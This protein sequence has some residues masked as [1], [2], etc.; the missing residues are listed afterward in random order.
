MKI[1]LNKEEA[2]VLV[3]LLDVAVKSGGLQ[4]AEAALYFAKKVDTAAK[5]E[6]KAEE[7]PPS[8]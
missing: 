1:D 6:A 2:Q 7:M 8:E 3:N 5:E 4:A